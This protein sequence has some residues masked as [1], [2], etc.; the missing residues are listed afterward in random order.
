[1]RCSSQTLL[2]QYQVRKSLM[3]KQRFIKWLKEHLNS[4]DYQIREEAFEKNGTNLVIGEL[5]TAEVI[6][7]A[8][9]D[10][11]PNG[12]IPVFMG[13][14]NW[15]SFF[16]SQVWVLLPTI[17][18]LHFTSYHIGSLIA[19]FS[20]NHVLM[21]LILGISCI[22]YLY[23][24]TKGF[25]NKHTANDNTSGVATLLAIL[26]DLP[27]EEREKVCVVFF[28]Q[29]EIGLV[30]AANFKRKHEA[31]VKDTPLINFDCVANGN[32]F[33]FVHKKKFRESFKFTQLKV[34]V[35]E[36]SLPETKFTHFGPALTHIYTSDQLIFKNSV[37]VV[38]AKKLPLFGYYINDIHTGLDT[39][40]DEQNIEILKEMM[41][42]FIRKI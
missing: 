36:V 9:Y 17:L 32:T 2:N 20:I 8:H 34:A 16:I 30:G 11:Q 21:A 27:K 19:D 10:T 24:L 41:L 38:A 6:L 23:Q 13:F 7:T 1:M 39:K 12:V 4:Y 22:L 3:E 29:E 5:E 33:C 25:A 37:G 28:D 15:L 42:E 35:E 14:S 26:E 18:L 40:F 31:E